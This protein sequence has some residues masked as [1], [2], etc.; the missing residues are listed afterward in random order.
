[1]AE[2]LTAPQQKTL[3]ELRKDFEV[4]PGYADIL[5]KAAV[6]GWST[7]EIIHAITNSQIFAR[8]FPGLMQHGTIAD[9]LSGR[10]NAPLS[11]QTLGQ[12]IGNYRTL[13]KS[14]ED[15]MRDFP[16]AM[17]GK[18]TRDRLATLIRAEKS[19]DEFRANLAAISTVQANPDLFAEWERIAKVA[20]L[21]QFNAFKVAGR[22]ADQKF[23]DVYEATRL[24]N[25]GL[26]LGAQDALKL[27]KNISNVDAA[28]RSTGIIDTGKLADL[29]GQVKSRQSDIGPELTAAGIPTLDLSK[30]I[31]TQGASDPTLSLQLEQLVASKRGGGAYV[32]GSQG[33]TGQAGGLATYKPEKAVNY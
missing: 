24:E 13:E 7:Q 22:I 5:R 29:V 32:A 18:L 6:Y 27:A 12:A 11:A 1:M 25:M 21:G 20:G 14:Y 33:R 31:A 4:L 2:P 28:G 8:Q 30:W 17:S 16:D 23:Y 19:P 10:A 9:F 3:K 26:G 15:A